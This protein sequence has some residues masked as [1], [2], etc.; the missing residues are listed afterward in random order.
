[1]RCLVTGVAGFVGSHLAERLIADGHDVCGIDAFIDYYPRHMKEKNLQAL[2]AEKRFTFVEGN[3]L[4]LE[5]TSLVEGVDW[6]FHQAAQAGVR[7]SWG[8]EFALYTDCNVLATQRLLEAVVTTGNHIQR[9]VYASSSSV[10]GDTTALPVREDVTPHPIS[11]YGVTKL[12]AEHLCSLYHHNFAV[13]T[14]SLRYFTVYGPRQRPD[15]AFHRFCKAIAEQQPIR[16]FDD[17]NQTRDFTYISDIVEANVRSASIGAP[18]SVMNIAG[19]SRVSVRQ[20]IE[21]L[22]EVSGLSAG[23]TFE[24]KQHGDVRNTF[25]DI[26]SATD[27]IGYEPRVTLREGLACEFESILAL[28][29]YKQRSIA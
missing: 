14:V 18:G 10:Y 26:S 21:L 25:A 5:L 29:G 12:A 9:L 3:L 24:Q 20:V 1:M 8:K 16:V 11:P 22:Q 4:D 23:V 7:A 15:M 17:G 2:R 28:Y 27:L 13:P 19:G 6:I